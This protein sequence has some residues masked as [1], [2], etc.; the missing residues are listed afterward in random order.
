MQISWKGQA[1]FQ[2]AASKAKQEQ[3]KIVIDPYEE[4][5][6]LRLS[7]LEADILL[8]THAHLDHDNKKAVKGDPFVIANPG[9]YE[10]KGAFIQGIAS[11]HDETQGKERGMNTMY[12]LEVEDMKICHL[13]DLGQKELTPDQ[14]NA[15]GDVDVLMIPVG[16]V[17]TIGAKEA[18]S[19]VS[20]IEPKIVIPMHYAIPKL[21][22]KLEGP[23][24]FL[25]I[26]GAK[27][28][29]PVEKLAIKAKD[30]EEDGIKI[31]VLQP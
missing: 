5:I 26:M 17:Y 20:Q 1:C 4:A 15:I 22:A 21:K 8:I 24:G 18:S 25:K 31:V 19:I 9:E 10:V 2:I 27:E 11:F 28:A 7:P 14:L 6:G 12:L 29:V 3:V 30:L 16:G 13:G 23:E